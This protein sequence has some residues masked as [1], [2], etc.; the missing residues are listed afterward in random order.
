MSERKNAFVDGEVVEGRFVVEACIG[1]GGMGEVYVAYD[2]RMDRRVVLKTLQTRRLEQAGYDE[3]SA[4]RMLRREAV[5]LQRARDEH[6]PQCYDL[7]EL[8][9]ERGLWIRFLSQEYIEGET[10][11]ERLGRERKAGKRE[12]TE[13]ACREVL[14]GVLSLLSKI[15]RM[16]DEKGSLS[17]LLHLDIKP[18][19]LMYRKSDG[20]LFLIDFGLA[21]RLEEVDSRVRSY[22]LLGSGIPGYMPPEQGEGFPCAASDVYALGVVVLEMATGHTAQE[23]RTVLSAEESARGRLFSGVPKPLCVVLEKMTRR[24]VVERYEDGAAAF[25]AWERAKR[26]GRAATS[27]AVQPKAEGG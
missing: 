24:E 26:G 12:S 21:V 27:K 15:H 2:K 1:R 8:E 13:E 18:G 23:L 22:S 25:D 14:E 7:H 9:R 4:L 11:E 5:R 16:K 20:R 19:N 10:L 3:A 17:P 6:V